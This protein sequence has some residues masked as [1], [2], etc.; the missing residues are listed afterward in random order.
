MYFNMYIYCTL[1]AAVS[2]TSAHVLTWTVQLHGSLPVD[3]AHTSTHST[4]ARRWKEQKKVFQLLGDGRNRKA[5][6]EK[7]MAT[8]QTN[9][10]N[11]L[12]SGHAQSSNSPCVCLYDRLAHAHTSCGTGGQVKS[13]TTTAVWMISATAIDEA[14]L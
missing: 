10:G 12:N 5:K 6:R 1:P 4:A 13:S 2:N 3:G 8:S 14:S 7:V 9:T 11:T